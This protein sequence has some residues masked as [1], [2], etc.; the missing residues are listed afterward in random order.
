MLLAERW[1]ATEAEIR[2]AWLDVTWGR[3]AG[4]HEVDDEQRGDEIVPESSR[5][6][7]WMH[8]CEIWNA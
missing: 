3:N 8:L 1:C 6:P 4:V 2:R 5:F 7:E